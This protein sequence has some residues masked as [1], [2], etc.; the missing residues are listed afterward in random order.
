MERLSSI[1]T[2]LNEITYNGGKIG[3]EPL[4]INSNWL[5]NCL[6]VDGV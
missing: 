1:P 6:E 4:G 2:L 5:P 3:F